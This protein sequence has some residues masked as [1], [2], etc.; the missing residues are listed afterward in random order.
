[1][2]RIDKKFRRYWK[3]YVFQSFFA[4]VAI[5]V[6]LFFF[7]IHRRPIIIASMGSTA[8]IVFALPKNLTAKPRRVVGSHLVGLLCGSLSVLIP[9][10]SLLSSLFVYS[11]AV[12]ASIF[13]MVVTD[14]EH[15]P[16]SGTALGI[17]IAGPSLHTIIAVIAGVVTLSLLHH[18]LSP[19]LRD[20]A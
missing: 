17:A 8:F 9:H 14:T 1:M 6:I 5:F 4:A 10:S 19:Y 2:F 3:N 18:F 15:P 11:F 13:L 20:L 16:A 12:G 7:N